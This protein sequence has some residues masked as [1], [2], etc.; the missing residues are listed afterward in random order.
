MKIKMHRA[1][2]GFSLLEVL[3]AI[4]ILSF[5]LLALATL[6]LSLFKSSAA[7]K[8]QSVALSL[9]KD[10]I[11][12]MRSFK[13]LGD[14]VAL[15]DS[16]PTNSTMGGV[17]YAVTTT[18]DRYVFGVPA[19]GT[20]E[21]KSVGDTTA[22]AT[23]GASTD[24]KYILGRDFK[25]VK[26]AVTWNESTGDGRTLT[27]EDVIDGLDPADSAKVVKNSTNTLPR[28]VQV[29]I[30]NPANEAGVIPIAIGDSTDTAATNPRP[31]VNSTAT[32]T[33][34]D[35]Y[36]YSALTGGNALAQSRVETNVIGCTCNTATAPADSTARGYRPTYWN[37]TRY[38]A[39]T[40]TTYAPP[41]GQSSAA[42]SSESPYCDICCR[43][44]NDPSGTTTA[45][46]DP[47]RATHTH[48]YRD[49]S[50]NLQPVDSSKTVYQEA[51]RLI[52]VDGIFR[53]AADFNNEYFNLLETNKEAGNVSTPTAPDYAPSGSTPNAVGNYQQMVLSYLDAK[54]VNNATP[55]TY[56]NSVSTKQLT[57]ANFSAATSYS[58]E[59]TAVTNL[60]TTNSINDPASV[61]ISSTADYQWLHSRG[62][63]ID[64]LEPETL[65]AIASAKQNCVTNSCTTAEKQTAVLQ[66]LPFTTI[67]LS[68]LSLW[69]PAVADGREVSVS[70]G[71][72]INAAS[73]TDPVR[74]RVVRNVSPATD[75]DIDATAKILASNSGLANLSQPID[76]DEVGKLDAQT[77]HV[78]A[79]A[80]STYTF[81]VKVYGL[82]DSG[83]QANFALGGAGITNCTGSFAKV[84]GNQVGTYTCTAS[85]LPATLSI[86]AY[87]YNY[88]SSS[89]SKGNGR[90]LACSGSAGWKSYTTTNSDTKIYTCPNF[91]V[92]T[93]ATGVVVSSPDGALAET[94]TTTVSVANGDTVNLTFETQNPSPNLLQ[95]PD[96]YGYSCVYSGTGPTSATVSIIAGTCP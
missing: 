59:S 16:G 15:T 56:N 45:K 75:A 66:L 53:V 41:A 51:C 44:H 73:S 49:N 43:D 27:L 5:G 81:T 91:N 93:P 87:K 2:R 42:A 94:S 39:P 88:Q 85:L 10:K 52:R 76:A 28:N 63:Y 24:P 57:A 70:S 38:V 31:V 46:F 68:E 72:F 86:I 77:F 80:A 96:G 12:T 37:G 71:A 8:A 74:G 29:I 23:L 21:F 14:Y 90:V 1:G 19:T 26:V 25:R 35:I 17:T 92:T 50:N 89:T 65:A 33:R 13:T 36:T 22:E 61:T 9:A 95:L 18:V 83:S 48:Y 69:K 40:L 84:T 4:V 47:W 64:Y 6:Q 30:S 54:V 82:E 34:F 58:A 20:A 62:L 32:E 67:N 7:S 11:E 79:T 78:P 3:I 55:T 60:E